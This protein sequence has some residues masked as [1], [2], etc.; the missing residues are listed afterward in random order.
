MPTILCVFAHPDDESFGSGGTIARYVAQ[1]VPVDLLCFTSGQVGATPEPIDTPE[2]L[3]LLRT[4]ELRAACRV[5]G[6]RQLTL[7]DYMDGQL[8][9]IDKQELAN[10]VLR[11]IEASNADTIVTFGQHGI[12]RHGDHIA[13]H[14]AAMAG[15][16]Q[17]SRSLRV[18]YG[19]VPKEFAKQFELEGP[20]AEPT[21]D[22]DI[23][24]FFDTK[25]DALACHSSQQDARE[26][27]L[28]VNNVKL[29]SEQYYRVLPPPEPGRTYQDLF[30]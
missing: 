16:D 6:I 28:M 2:K 10:H 3:G 8:D 25:L 17:A 21:H 22:I 13:A 14:K 7:L 9:Q 19:A 27:F 4:H 18:F 29:M 30:E 24:E 23:T 12:T 20:E 26:F 5:L 11:Q 1:G 15:V